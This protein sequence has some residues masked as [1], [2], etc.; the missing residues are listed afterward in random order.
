MLI[1]CAPCTA[2]VIVYKHN[3]PLTLRNISQTQNVVQSIVEE[4]IRK[5]QS[6]GRVVLVGNFNARVGK[7]DGV[8]DVIGRFGQPGSILAFQDLCYRCRYQYPA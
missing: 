7:V 6:K 8:D 1:S 4:D 5:F 2:Q 3:P